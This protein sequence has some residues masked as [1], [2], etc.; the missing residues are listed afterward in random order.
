MEKA[1]L[2]SIIMEGNDTQEKRA[3]LETQI[4]T[5][6]K[7]AGTL[8]TEV[9]DHCNAKAIQ[10]RSKGGTSFFQ[11]TTPVISLGE[12]DPS[13][14]KGRTHGFAQIIATLNH[15]VTFGP[16]NKHSFSADAKDGITV[17]GPGKEVISL[18]IDL[19]G[20]APDGSDLS[21][22]N[23]KL[24]SSNGITHSAYMDVDQELAEQLRTR[25]KIVGILEIIAVEIGVRLAV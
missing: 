1:E 8:A 21:K 24:E 3:K 12:V 7:K 4:R 16:R 14:T 22:I 18:Q 2:L 23:E 19:Y 9:L 10:P 17:N 6:H 20:G 15:D 5:A 13:N 25:E 11:R